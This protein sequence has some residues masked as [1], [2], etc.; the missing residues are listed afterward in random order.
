MDCQQECYL[1]NINLIIIKTEI[2]SHNLV[3]QTLKFTMYNTYPLSVITW[4]YDSEMNYVLSNC[5]QNTNWI[6]LDF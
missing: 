6:Q 3:Y 4:N 5:K 1:G 2:Y